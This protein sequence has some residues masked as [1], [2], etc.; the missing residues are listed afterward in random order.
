M[1]SRI[2]LISALLV[3]GFVYFT[4]HR[5]LQGL[6]PSPASPV[7]SPPNSVRGAGL[8]TDELNNIEV[9]KMANQATVNITSTVVQQDWFRGVYKA[10]AAGSGFAIDADGKILT[11][12]HVVSGSN[13][14]EVVLADQ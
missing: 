6:K 7:W 10:T 14:I 5:N 12:N 4:S 1:K 8:G 2:I 11:N 9:Y 13:K 3:G